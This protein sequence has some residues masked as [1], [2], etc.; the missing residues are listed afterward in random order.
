MKS[1]CHDFTFVKAQ[2]CKFHINNIVLCSV[3]QDVSNNIIT[4]KN[5]ETF[6]D[7]TEGLTEKKYFLLKLGS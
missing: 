1:T 5:I 6:D 3:L 7:H 4:L 2:S